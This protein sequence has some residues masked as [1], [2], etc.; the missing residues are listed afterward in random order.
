MD[1]FSDK[2]I[3]EFLKVIQ[4]KSRLSNE[5]LSMEVKKVLHDIFG[6]AAEQFIT[7]VQVRKG[8]A[9]ITSNSSTFKHELSH[10]IELLIK[11][12]NKQM[13]GYEISQVV[14]Y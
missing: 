3:S 7:R 9:Y 12:I 11:R 5:L 14:L 1:Q 13:N 2:P 8:V 4:N 10:S 6:K